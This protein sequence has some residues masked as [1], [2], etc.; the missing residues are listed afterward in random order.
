MADRLRKDVRRRFAA[1]GPTITVS[2]GVS[3]I[4]EPGTTTAFEL[5]RQADKALLEAKRTGKD[6]V[7]RC[8]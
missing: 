6:K 7:I 2:I 4:H 1:S 3:C 8:A 5:V